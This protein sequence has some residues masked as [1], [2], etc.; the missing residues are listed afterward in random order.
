MSYSDDITPSL[1][2]LLPHWPYSA[3]KDLGRQRWTV[4]AGLGYETFPGWDPATCSG[5][6]QQNS[7]GLQGVQ[8]EKVYEA[9]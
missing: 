7:L 4:S 3:S 2:L 9:R 8:P 1:A 5:Q 6:L